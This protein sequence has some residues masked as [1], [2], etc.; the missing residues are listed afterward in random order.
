MNSLGIVVEYNPFHNGHSYHIQESVKATGA[1]LV[2]AVMSGNFLQ[3]GEPAL[4]NKWTRTQM[5]LRAGVDIVFELPY[6][7]AAQQADIFAKG[8]IGILEAARCNSVC[9][10]SEVGKIDPFLEVQSFMKNHKA[11]YDTSVKEFSKAGYSYP[12]AS[13]LAFKKVSQDDELLDLTKPNN[14][15]GLQYVQAIVQGSYSIKPCTIQRIMADYH[16]TELGTHPIA[17]A[18]GIR[19]TLFEQS[20]SIDPI[21][22]Q[23]PASTAEELTRYFNQFKTFHNWELYWPLLQYRIISS[24]SVELAKIYEVEEGLEN[25]FKAAA[26]TSVSFLEFM[27]TVKTKR[28]TWTRLQRVSLNILMN[29]SK[30]I[31]SAESIEPAYL[32]LLGATGKGRQ[33]L[34]QHKKKLGLPLI[35]KPSSFK[36]LLETD[37]MASKIYALPLKPVLQGSLMKREFQPPVFIEKP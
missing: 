26:E 13:S 20:L 19:K 7:F 2:V 6:P 36:P 34:N 16:S 18:T 15:L 21:R 30:E 32:R 31:M 24:P 33:Y 28:Y 12:R 5:A 27:E 23:V 4:V 25:R 17:S 14:I 11:E 35:T 10:G 37:I 9:F 8:A 3:R 1:D 22:N 29:R